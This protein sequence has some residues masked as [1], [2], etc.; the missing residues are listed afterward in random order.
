MLRSGNLLG[1]PFTDNECM[2]IMSWYFSNL[3][4]FHTW[5]QTSKEHFPWIL[6]IREERWA[7]GW[8][9]LVGSSDTL[10][11]LEA[12]LSHLSDCLV[13]QY[14]L[15]LTTMSFKLETSDICLP[16]V[17]HFADDGVSKKDYLSHE[18]LVLLFCWLC[19]QT[20]FDFQ[21][22]MAGEIFTKIM[23]L[24]HF[25]NSLTLL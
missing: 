25:I 24:P 10:S 7:K 18:E 15:Q 13:G 1:N 22:A 19:L 17:I 9:N 6:V 14:F 23:S 12:L 21:L 16:Q 20:Y 3:P 4:T 8:E 11:C 2:F 5:M